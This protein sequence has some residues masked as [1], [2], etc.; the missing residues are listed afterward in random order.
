MPRSRIFVGPIGLRTSLDF[1]VCAAALSLSFRPDFA[2]ARALIVS[3]PPFAET[4][5]GQLTRANVSLAVRAGTL[6]E[7]EAARYWKA[8]RRFRSLSDANSEGTIAGRTA[9]FFKQIL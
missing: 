4:F 8:R 5:A 2:T 6:T 7:E 1:I 3:M 9:E